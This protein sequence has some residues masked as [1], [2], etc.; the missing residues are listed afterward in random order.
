MAVTLQNCLD[1]I[2]YIGTPTTS[3]SDLTEIAEKFAMN[4]PF[5]SLHIDGISIFT[6]EMESR[7]RI[8]TDGVGGTCVALSCVFKFIMDEIGFT[9]K[10]VGLKSGNAYDKQSAVVVTIG[11]DDWVCIFGYYQQK[12]CGPLKLEDAYSSGAITISYVDPHYTV[13]NTQS[14]YE[15][16]IDNI[17]HPLSYWIPTATDM[18]TSGMLVDKNMLFI[19]TGADTARVYMDGT[20][21][22]IDANG[23]S[24]GYEHTTE[25]L[26]VLFK[27]FGLVV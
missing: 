11:T 2:G 3:L 17:D 23:D 1:K 6:D 5:S 10:Y 4:C 16:D 8:I 24:T 18:S 13:A 15:L 25:D 27:Y 22:D 26:S 14:G 9:S 7:D 20:I 19:C 12:I 21:T